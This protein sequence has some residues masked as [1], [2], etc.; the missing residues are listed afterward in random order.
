[1]KM[2]YKILTKCIIMINNS[3]ISINRIAIISY[4]N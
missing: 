3:K 1:M 2:Q 4:D